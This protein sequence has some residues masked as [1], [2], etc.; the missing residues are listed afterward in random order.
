MTIDLVDIK[1]KIEDKPQVIILLNS[2][3]D[4][5]KDVK[6]GNMYRRYILTFVLVVS[7][8]RYKDRENK[9]SNKNDLSDGLYIR[10]RIDKRE[11]GFGGKPLNRSKFRSKKHVKCYFCGKKKVSILL[12]SERILINKSYVLIMI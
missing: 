3:P 8:L 4:K 10:D 12:G 6:S 1:Q 7:S 5:Y 9:V 11:N 2:L